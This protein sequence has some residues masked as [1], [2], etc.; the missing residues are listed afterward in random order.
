MF[1][2]FQAASPVSRQPAMSVTGEVL[3]FWLNG[4][5][6]G[7][8]DPDTPEEPGVPTVPDQPPPVPVA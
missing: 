7:Q 3:G 8:P 6:P 2:L 1:T 5:I 4:G